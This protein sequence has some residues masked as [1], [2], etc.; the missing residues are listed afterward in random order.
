MC[1]LLHSKVLAVTDVGL[2]PTPLQ[3]GPQ[4][5]SAFSPGMSLQEG[6]KQ[7]SSPL[8]PSDNSAQPVDWVMTTL[9]FLFPALL[10][11]CFGYDI[12]ASSGALISLTDKIKSG[13]DW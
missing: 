7:P 2:L 12:G 6:G 11:G 1:C 5:R 3:L 8:Q 10:G 9:L 13:T 4:Y